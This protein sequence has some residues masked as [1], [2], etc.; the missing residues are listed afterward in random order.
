MSSPVDPDDVPME[1]DRSH[2]MY[3]LKLSRRKGAL[4]GIAFLIF[5]TTIM[6]IILASTSHVKSDSNSSN[7]TAPRNATLLP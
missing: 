3:Y 1:Y 7:N 5:T 4:M 6:I 2:P